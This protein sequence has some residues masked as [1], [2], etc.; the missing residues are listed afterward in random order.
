[1]EVRMLHAGM[2]ATV[3]D[4]GRPGNR[5]AGVPRGGAMDTFALRVANALVGNAEAAAALEFALVGPEMEFSDDTIIA[6]A[7]VE[8]G[9]LSTWRPHFVRA[10]ER[11]KLGTCM[12]GCWGYLAIA[13]GIDVERVLGSGSTYLRGGFGGVEGRALRAGDVLRIGAPAAGLKP[14]DELHWQIDPRVLPRYGSPATVRVLPGAQAGEFDD[15]LTGADFVVSPKSD[16][17]GIRLN[18]PK[19]TRTTKADLLST[20]VAPGTVQVPPDGQPVVLMADAGTIGGYPQVAHVIAVD[21]PV[22]AQLR[23]GDTVR[24]SAVTLDEAHRLAQTRERTLGMLHE[25]LAEKLGLRPAGA[26]R[27]TE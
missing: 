21:Q 3:Q 16:R 10:G 23:P 20:A 17:I 15:A 24:F 13:G 26:M 25:G 9:S 19:L 4:L 11:L 7:G 18:G 14:L 27:K 12:R 1:M 22:M 6:V 5:A 8:L 2:Q